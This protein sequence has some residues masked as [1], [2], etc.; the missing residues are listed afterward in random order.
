MLRQVLE[1]VVDFLDE[2]EIVPAVRDLLSKVDTAT[3]VVAFWGKG[4]TER[5]GL[6]KE[7]ASLT[8]VCNLDS[9]ACNPRVIKDLMSLPNVTV[10][11]DRRLHGKV[12]LTDEAVILGSSNASANGLVVEDDGLVGW[13]EANIVSWDPSFRARTKSW[14][15]DRIAAAQPIEAAD[16]RRAEKAWRLRR[17]MAPMRGGRTADLLKAVRRDP[18]HPIWSSVKIVLWTQYASAAAEQEFKQARRGGAVAEGT[19]Y[20]EGWNGTL[21]PGDWLVDFQ[22]GEGPAAF[23]GYWNVLDGPVTATSLTWVREEK[24]VILPGLGQFKLSEEDQTQI[25]GQAHQ[26]LQVFPGPENGAAVLGI[27]E[28]VRLLRDASPS[29]ASLE[30][31]FKKAMYKIY[32]DAKDAGHTAHRFR[33]MIDDEGALRA[34]STLIAK[35]PS[36]GFAAL[37][38]LGRLD[39]TVEALVIQPKWSPLFTEAQQKQALRVLKQ[40]GWP[41]LGR[42]QTSRT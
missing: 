41:S 30:R 28:L 19:D 27:V 15:E 2:S 3:I 23:T 37:W 10:L 31:A 5:L 13:A 34:A 33:E 14:C 8:I 29:R 7:W 35:S 40:N 25:A 18:R 11:N 17:K 16:L 38:E 4:A 6:E 21:V 24:A 36:T 20:Y 12:Y 42:V 22:L 26:I 32:D 39:L 1:G 9:G